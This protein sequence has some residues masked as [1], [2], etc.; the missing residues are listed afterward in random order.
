MPI[1]LVSSLRIVLHF[2]L[3]L[4]EKCSPLYIRY[5]A[6]FLNLKLKTFC[7]DFIK[8]LISIWLFVEFNIYMLKLQCIFIYLNHRRS[9]CSRF[10]EK[11][12]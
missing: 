3:I 12:R 7:L 8:A 4:L 11:H 6:L 9:D 1:N 2:Y 5:S 10:S